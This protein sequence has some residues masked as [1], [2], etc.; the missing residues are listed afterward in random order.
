LPL[1]EGHQAALDALATAELLQAQ[2]QHH[3]SPS[4]AISQLWV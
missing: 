4:T 2:I 1:Y 3:Y